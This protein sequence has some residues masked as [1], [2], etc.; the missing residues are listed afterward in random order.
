MTTKDL[1]NLRKEVQTMVQKHLEKTGKT[2]SSLANEAG[3]HPA[4]LLLFMRS[5]RGLTDTSLMRLGEVI[6]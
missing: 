2:A 1:K 3:I 4:Q 5:E 6:D